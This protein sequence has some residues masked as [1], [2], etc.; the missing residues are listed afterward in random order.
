MRHSLASIRVQHKDAQPFKVTGFGV[1]DRADGCVYL[2]GS[3]SP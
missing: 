3:V 1:N 2:S